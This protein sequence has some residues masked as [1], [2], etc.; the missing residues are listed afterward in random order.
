MDK[1]FDVYLAHLIEEGFE[2]QS[3]PHITPRPGYYGRL[4]WVNVFD[5]GDGPYE[6][7]ME[8]IIHS[9]VSAQDA[10]YRA[11][12]FTKATALYQPRGRPGIKTLGITKDVPPQYRR[13]SDEK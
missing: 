5:E 7:H 9:L 6:M 4:R 12:A 1:S 3:G 13:P 10:L 8:T 11:E 2:V